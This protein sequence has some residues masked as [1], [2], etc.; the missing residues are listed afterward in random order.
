M[1]QEKRLSRFAVLPQP[2]YYAVIF[3]SQC[4]DNRSGYG[5]TAKLTVNPAALKIGFLGAESV[6]DAR[7]TGIAVSYW[8]DETAIAVWKQHAENRLAQERGKCD[9]YAAYQVRAAKVR[10]ADGFD[11]GG[12]AA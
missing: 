6:R 11:S 9:R 3:T 10:R 5:D 7:S 8:Q 12:A 4:N 1:T 2:P